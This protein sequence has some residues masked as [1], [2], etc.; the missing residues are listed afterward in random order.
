MTV[1][2]LKNVVTVP[3]AAIQRGPNGAFVYVIDPESNASQKPV[4]LLRQTESLTAIDQGIAE[5]D[6]VVTNGFNRLND[7]TRVRIDEARPTANG[8]AAKSGRGGGDR[9]ARDKGTN[10][11]PK[12]QGNGG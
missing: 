11:A 5:G 9:P 4:T 2:T 12:P 8:P 6:M 10:E 1:D 7:N 3:T